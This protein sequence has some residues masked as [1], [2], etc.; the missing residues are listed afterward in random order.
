MKTLTFTALLFAAFVLPVLAQVPG[1]IPARPEK[2]QYGALKF[3]VPEADK[4]R[5]QLKNG[6]SVYLVEDHSLPLVNI[7]VTLRSGSFAEPKDKPG[8]ASLTATMM[9]KGGAGGLTA[10]QFDERADFLAVNINS[11]SGETQAGLSANSL[12]SQLEPSL[13][14]LFDLLK[15]PRFQADRIEIEK[16][17]LLELI[18]QRNDDAGAILGR[19][20]GWL[21]YGEEFFAT[22]KITKA[23]LD[24]ITRD[25]LVAFHKA[26]Y[27]PEGMVIAVSGDVDAKAILA[28]LDK[29]FEG[30]RPEGSAV[31]WPPTAPTHVPKAGV[32]HVEKDIPQGKVNIGHLG[33]KHDAQWENPDLFALDVMN[34]VL[35]GSGFTSRITKRV[36][37]DEGLA[38]SAGS[39][40]GVGVFWPGVFRIFFQTKNSTVAYAAK[41]SLAEMGRIQ[42]EP[43]S[44]SELSTAKNASIETFPR[45]FESAGKIASL[46]ASDDYLGRPHAYWGKFR[47]N[48]RKVGPADV[49][50]VAKS[51]L[52]PDQVV[53]LIVGKWADIEKGDPDGKASMKEFFGG[54]VTHLPLRDPLTL[55]PIK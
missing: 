17:Q 27:R 46:F 16:G 34:D 50:R 44:D 5:F 14:L 52:A 35:G 36:R 41:L 30:W 8:V 48:V 26:T 38:Y 31:A 18:K 32:Y 25:D 3:D 33:A 20:W 47:D 12:S 53:F 43:V 37:S 45:N 21:M 13:D 1:P 29:R 6:T 49:Q 55:Q 11:Y 51:Y 9:R 28:G 7:A 15:A 42:T 4:Y 10:E 39:L 19:E 40:Y 24:S 54:Q 22:R 23:Q 2:I